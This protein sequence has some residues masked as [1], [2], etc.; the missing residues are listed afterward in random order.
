MKTTK[1]YVGSLI[2]A[3]AGTATLKT[4]FD[5][6]AVAILA[7]VGQGRGKFRVRVDGGAWKTVS[8]KASSGAQ[9]RVVWTARLSNGDHRLEIQRVSGKPAID[10]II[11]VR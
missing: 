6:K 3:T 7:P 5:G 11:F 4:K 9:R 1:A 2:Y 10:G 8:T